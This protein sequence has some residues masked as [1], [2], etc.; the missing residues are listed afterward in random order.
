MEY[1]I[2]TRVEME[3]GVLSVS[4]ADADAGEVLA[5]CI[6]ALVWRK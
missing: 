4:E 3:C 6:I 2:V 5:K 1:E